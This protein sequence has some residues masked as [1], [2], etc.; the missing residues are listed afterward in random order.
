[1]DMTPPNLLYVTTDGDTIREKNGV[2]IDTSYDPSHF[3]KQY[4]KIAVT[5]DLLKGCGLDVGADVLFHHFV[6]LESN[7]ETNHKTNY[8]SFVSD[9][10]GKRCYPCEISQLIAFYDKI[11]MSWRGVNGW[12]IGHPIL[13]KETVSSLL[14]VYG[15]EDKSTDYVVRVLSKNS[16]C[17]VNDVVYLTKDCDYK[18]Q[19]PDGNEA[20][21]FNQND[22]IALK[23]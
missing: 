10:V 19:M 13:N 4:G 16:I 22:I 7:T 15:D 5:N 18:I 1:M 2:I 3:A 17:Q 14:E 8:N 11:E 12:V 21:A 9:K 20:W 6:T 23:K